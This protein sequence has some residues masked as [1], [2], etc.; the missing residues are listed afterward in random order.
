M[1]KSYNS[2]RWLRLLGLA[3][4]LLSALLLTLLLESTSGLAAPAGQN[5]PLST[6]SPVETPTAT[7]SP[8][9]TATSPVPPTA[10]PPTGLQAWPTPTP[11]AYPLPVQAAMD[12]LT[13]DAALG[14]TK[15]EPSARLLVDDPVSGGELTVVRLLDPSAGDTYWLQVD[16]DGVA[17]LLPDF[18]EAAVS[19]VAASKKVD[20]ADLQ[21][22]HSLYVPF[23]FT[24]QILWIGQLIDKKDGSQLSTA[25]DLAG[26]EVDQTGASETE[27]AAI[28]DYCGAIDVSLCLEM[29]YAPDGSHTFAA[30]VLEEEADPAPIINFLDE[31]QVEYRQDEEVF[32]FRM[33][34]EDLRALAQLE[35]IETIQKDYPD[36]MRPLDT[37]LILGLIEESG[38]LSLTLESQQP[39]PLLNYRVE[40]LLQAVEVTQTQSITLL[41]Q[42]G[43]IFA[44]A[45]GPASLS[46]AQGRLAL[47]D[48]SGR[49]N[50]TLVY[51]DTERSLDLSDNY[52]LIISDGRA[53]IRPGELSFSWPKYATWLRL[54]ANAL[55]FVVQARSTDGEGTAYATERDDFTA[56]SDAFY[57]D[58]AG[59]RARSLSLAEGIY[60]NNLFVPPWA[61]W[62]IPDGELVR[63]P[64]SESQSYLFKWPDIRYFTYTG[65]L[66]SIE[67]LIREHCVEEVAILVYTADGAIL[68]VCQP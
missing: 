56:K 15:A 37:N 53:V 10:E 45:A 17:S 52:A 7:P 11:T 32:Y 58:V 16:S 39:Y 36:E 42:I 27:A 14:V 62:Q 43:G 1:T 44:P 30:L 46:P 41:A 22:F 24:R 49:Y 66:R 47:G 59:L 54:P 67:G 63:V 21:L 26:E 2:N 51:T 48:L 20:V 19:L 3:L 33:A 29:L 35:N 13:G 55:W 61:T 57:A 40:A 8:T 23:P 6:V 64:V 34:N 18:S 5:S 50:L 31:W 12:A 9:P 60:T 28:Q 65:T 68:D 25:L 38:A 4:L